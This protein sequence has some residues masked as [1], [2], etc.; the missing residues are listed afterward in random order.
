MPYPVKKLDLLQFDT[1]KSETLLLNEICN[2]VQIEP[3]LQSLSGENFDAKTANKHEDA[4]LDISARGFWCSGQKALFDVSVFNPIASRYR[5][6]PL[7][8]CYS[9][10]ENEKKK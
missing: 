6:T 9:I 7:S 3:Q 8:K 10:N 4:R 2:D 5:N 1:T